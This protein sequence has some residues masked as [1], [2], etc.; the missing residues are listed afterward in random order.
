MIEVLVVPIFFGALVG[1]AIAWFLLP[2]I[3]CV[4]VLMS[5]GL[6]V[7]FWRDSGRHNGN[8][9][10]IISGIACLFFGSL[11]SGAGFVYSIFVAPDTW[12][13]LWNWFAE[14]IRLVLR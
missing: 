9:A 10:S 8:E 6:C 13:R 1:G 12:G 7:Y 14:G 3:T 11:M 2:V 4:I 5:L